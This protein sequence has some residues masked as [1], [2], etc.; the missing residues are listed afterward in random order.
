M[1]YLKRLHPFLLTFSLNF[2][3]HCLIYHFISQ[4]VG[5][6]KN[7]LIFIFRVNR[8]D[9]NCIENS[10]P[11]IDKNR[12]KHYIILFMGE[13]TRNRRINL[14][15]KDR[16]LQVG[17]LQDLPKDQAEV[18]ALKIITMRPRIPIRRRCMTSQMIHGRFRSLLDS[19]KSG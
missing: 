16:K 14:D 9:R 19:L 18:E 8:N 12:Q 3:C 11:K 2:A 10:A 17:D 6:T 15:L 7:Q 5:R 4:I 1:C 13:E